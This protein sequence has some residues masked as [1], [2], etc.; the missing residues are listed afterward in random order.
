MGHLGRLSAIPT[1]VQA[2][3]RAADAAGGARPGQLPRLRS[4][5]AVISGR[6]LTATWDI[7]TGVQVLHDDLAMVRRY[8]SLP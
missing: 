3:Q 8:V 7:V 5:G 4:A 2:Q 6:Y 1:I